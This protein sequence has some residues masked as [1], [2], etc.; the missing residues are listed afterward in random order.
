MECGEVMGWGD[1]AGLWD[2]GHWGKGINGIRGAVE[3][4]GS[5]ECEG[6]MGWGGAMR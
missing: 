2:G 3:W 4:G 5:M 1:N 6:A